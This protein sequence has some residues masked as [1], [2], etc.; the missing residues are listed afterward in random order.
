MFVQRHAATSLLP[1]TLKIARQ[2]EM[3]TAR[4]PLKFGAVPTYH[5]AVLRTGDI[6]HRSYDSQP[7]SVL[8]M[9]VQ[10]SIQ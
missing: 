1:P 2:S 9:P 6:A 4:I 5:V 10:Y 3:S 7:Y 8:Y